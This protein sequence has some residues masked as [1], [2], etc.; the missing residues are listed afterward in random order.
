ML[1]FSFVCT[2]CNSVDDVEVA[3]HAPLPAAPEA[4]LCTRC[5]YGQWHELFPQEQYDPDK[6]NVIN[7]PTGLSL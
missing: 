1:S 4:Q 3:F 6:H 5:Q 2:C 7:R